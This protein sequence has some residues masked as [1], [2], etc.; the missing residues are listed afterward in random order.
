MAVAGPVLTG[1]PSNSAP[2]PAAAPV[3]Q[4]GIEQPVRIDHDLRCWNALQNRFRP[5]FHRVVSPG[6]A[7][8]TRSGELH[9]GEPSG[10]FRARSPPA[11]RIA[12][13]VARTPVSPASMAGATQV[14]HR[15]ADRTVL[16]H[17]RSR[18]GLRDRIREAHY[19][20]VV[21]SREHVVRHGARFR[22]ERLRAVGLVLRGKDRTCGKGGR[23]DRDR[24]HARPVHGRDG[25][26]PRDRSATN[27]AT[28][29][30][31]EDGYI[32]IH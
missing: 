14:F 2:T 27:A 1:A 17:H 26:P 13:G 19:V 32:V 6:R 10:E 5:A 9:T 12:N 18:P 25:L 30:C 7:A 23:G 4:P 28:E 11:C 22:R 16:A 20:I 24:S 31:S 15:Q 29:R 8:T 3:R 21:A